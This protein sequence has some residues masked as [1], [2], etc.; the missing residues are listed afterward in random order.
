MTERRLRVLA[1]VLGVGLC[2]PAAMPLLAQA[3]LQPAPGCADLDWNP[4]TLE[5]NPDITRACRGVYQ[6]E[7]R[8]YARVEVEVVKVQGNRIVYKPRY[9][10][11]S[12]GAPRG[13]DAARGF[14]VTIEGQAYSASQLQRGQRLTVYL[15]E[16]RFVLESGQLHTDPAAALPVQAA[17]A[18]SGGEGSQAASDSGG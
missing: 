15:P 4:A 8:L 7:G 1:L 16:D 6:R 13:V 10:D 5:A 2:G 9:T 12:F 18:A 17:P 14:R 3:S 11:G